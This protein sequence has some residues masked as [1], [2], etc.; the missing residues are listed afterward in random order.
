MALPRQF[1]LVITPSGQTEMT[2]ANAAGDVQD[3]EGQVSALMDATN[4][5][6][7]GCAAMAPSDVQAWNGIYSAWQT[8]DQD[9]QSCIAGVPA[10]QYAPPTVSC[11]FTYGRNWATALSKLKSYQ[12]QASAWQ[13]RVHAACANY[14]P[15][16]GPAS[17]PSGGGTTAQ[18]SW[19]CRTFGFG[20]GAAGAPAD[21]SAA[22]SSSVGWPDAIKWAAILGIIGITVW[23][24]GPFIA[25]VAGVGAGAIRKRATRSEEFEPVALFKR[26]GSSGGGGDFSFGNFS[27][28]A[29]QLAG[30]EFAD[31]PREDVLALIGSVEQ[32]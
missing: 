8:F 16:P 26:G 27:R 30:L 3:L 9:L 10:D 25:T 5:A 32:E 17:Q 6:V 2:G 28:E 21:A 19:M 4:G 11:E 15:L 24:I 13:A 31:I 22:A 12:S 23:Y 14:Q 7:M 20:C 1:Q 29:P 18:G